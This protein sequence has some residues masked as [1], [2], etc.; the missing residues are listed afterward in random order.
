MNPIQF[1]LDDGSTL[2]QAVCEQTQL[3]GEAGKQAAKGTGKENSLD[4]QLVRA[5]GAFFK[6]CVCIYLLP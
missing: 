6:T 4:A 2:P 3:I 1:E 5:S